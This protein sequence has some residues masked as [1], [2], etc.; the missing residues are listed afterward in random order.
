MCKDALNETQKSGD[1]ASFSADSRGFFFPLWLQLLFALPLVSTIYPLGFFSSG[2]KTVRQS[3]VSGSCKIHRIT[4]AFPNLPLINHSPFLYFMLFLIHLYTSRYLTHH[5]PLSHSLSFWP[6][7]LVVCCPVQLLTRFLL[8]PLYLFHHPDLPSLSATQSLPV[9]RLCSDETIKSPFSTIFPWPQLLL[10]PL[11]L[12]ADWLMFTSCG[13]C[14]TTVSFCNRYGVILCK[15]AFTCILIW[16]CTS[17]N[18]KTWVSPGVNRKMAVSFP[19]ILW[20][21]WTLS[22]CPLLNILP[23]EYQGITSGFWIAVVRLNVCL[24]C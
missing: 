4:A 14:A 19:A 7:L 1:K 16:W 2:K 3:S 13:D 6:F 18:S 8:P 22:T 24:A 11:F 23:T 10:A 9:L 21:T 17:W 5:H 15:P 20:I 12:F